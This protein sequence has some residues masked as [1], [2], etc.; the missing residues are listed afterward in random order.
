VS[1]VV[2]LNFYHNFPGFLMRYSNFENRCESG[3]FSSKL[4]SSLKMEPS[5]SDGEFLGP[6]H[7]SY[8]KKDV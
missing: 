1:F 5:C 3:F 7:L 6:I 8:L 2:L 4:I